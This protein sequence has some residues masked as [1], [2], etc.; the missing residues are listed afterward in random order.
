[1]NE[2]EL[3]ELEKRPEFRANVKAALL[4]WGN[5]W[6]V[7]S[8]EEVA[9]LSEKARVLRKAMIKFIF[10]DA[11]RA[12]DAVASMVIA[13]ATIKAQTCYHAVT[14]EKVKT[15][16]DSLLGKDVSWFV[17]EGY[18]IL[19]KQEEAAANA[20]GNEGESGG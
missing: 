5:Y 14:Y 20:A 11:D 7:E 18:V 19:V 9:A 10:D 3:I 12:T 4:Y 16:V 13:D 15:V 8:P 1:M 6:R 2:I 17:P